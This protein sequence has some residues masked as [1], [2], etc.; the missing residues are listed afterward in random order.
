MIDQTH[1]KQTER[2][3]EIQRKQADLVEKYKSDNT[4]LT[5]IVRNID[6]AQALQQWKQCSSKRQARMLLAPHV[7]SSLPFNATHTVSVSWGGAQHEG[8]F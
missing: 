3:K 8:H 2:L 7:P 5:K 6:A 1:T 4:K